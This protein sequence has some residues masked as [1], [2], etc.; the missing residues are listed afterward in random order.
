M[1]LGAPHLTSPL[2]GPFRTNL[3]VASNMTAIPRDPGDPNQN[4]PVRGGREL[5]E[6]PNRTLNG[7]FT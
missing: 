5:G 6:T 3:A 1:L 4:D 2:S 7:L